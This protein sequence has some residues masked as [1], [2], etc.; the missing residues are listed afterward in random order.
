MYNPN[1]INPNEPKP[2]PEPQAEQETATAPETTSDGNKDTEQDTEQDTVPQPSSAPNPKE[3]KEEVAAE[4]PS[5]T[6]PTPATPD[7]YA[8]RRKTLKT[9]AIMAAI[10]GFL[11]IAKPWQTGFDQNDTTVTAHAE[12]PTLT[13]QD[14]TATPAIEAPFQKDVETANAHYTKHGTYDNLTLDGAQVAARDQAWYTAREHAGTCYA[15][16]MVNGEE[17]APVA[18][19]SGGACSGELAAVQK[20]LDNH[21]EQ[22]TEKST[23]DATKQLHDAARLVEAYTSRNYTNGTPSTHDAPG[24]FG[25]AL[26]KENTGDYVLLRVSNPETCQEMYVTASGEWGEVNPC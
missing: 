25:N 22:T 24:T 7:V 23:T 1:D 8:R 20:E 2:E 16:G 11:L 14:D 5:A 10:G 21:H 4:T 26:V 9:I 18:D 15:Y 3:Q 17:L 6:S 13:N 19:P 12:E